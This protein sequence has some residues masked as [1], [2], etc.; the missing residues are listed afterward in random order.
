MVFVVAKK[1]IKKENQGAFLEL[2]R[3]LVD[4]TRKEA[5]CIEYTLTSTPEHQDLLVYVEKWESQA[6]LDAHLQSE[7]MTRLRPA[8]NALC[9]NTKLMILSDAFEAAGV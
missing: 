3:E 6:H 5:G 8:M 9:D 1:I 2:A 4:C 7:H